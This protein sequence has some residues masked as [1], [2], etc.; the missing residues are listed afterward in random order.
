MI[1]EIEADAKQFGDERRTLILEEKKAVAEIKVVDE[2]VT[3]VVSQ[4][5]WVRTQPFCETTTVTGSSTTLISA[6]AFFSSRMRVRRSS[7]NCLA[8]A[9][10]SLI[11]CRRSTDG[12]SMMSRSFFSSSRRVESSC[13]ILMA[14]SLAS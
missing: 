4:K 9:S 10:I 6:T 3:V 8:S 11:I 14:S 12:L 1:K 7:P 2:P 13:S 5:G